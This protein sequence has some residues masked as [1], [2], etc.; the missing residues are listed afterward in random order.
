MCK[1]YRNKFIEL[2]KYSA[3]NEAMTQQFH[4]RFKEIFIGKF[5]TEFER[6]DFILNSLFKLIEYLLI[7]SSVFFLTYKV[8]FFKLSSPLLLLGPFCFNYHQLCIGLPCFRNSDSVHLS[9]SV[10]LCSE[11]FICIYAT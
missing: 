9:V 1:N 8:L 3:M 10:I 5:T 4:H 7:R 11:I 6:S 2:I